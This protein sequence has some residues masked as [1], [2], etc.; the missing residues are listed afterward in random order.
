MRAFN[1]PKLCVVCQCDSRKLRFSSGHC[2]YEEATHVTTPG[3][4]APVALIRVRCRQGVRPGGIG[5]VRRDTEQPSLC[6]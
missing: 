6:T 5:S 1:S 4:V 2:F 3:V